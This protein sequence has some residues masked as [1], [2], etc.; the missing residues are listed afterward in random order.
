MT[1]SL[2]EYAKGQ[3]RE[4]IYIE[5]P[6]DADFHELMGDVFATPSANERP[7]P[8]GCI[9][10]KVWLTLPDGTSL[11]AMSFKGDLDGWRKAFHRYCQSTGRKSAV[12][13][14]ETLLLC[15]GTTVPV[16]RCSIHHD[17]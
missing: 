4:A 14:G 10:E 17:E 12:L 8:G 7:S 6:L 9:E 15:D 13:A 5:A 3:G 16:A 2:P 11:L 1:N